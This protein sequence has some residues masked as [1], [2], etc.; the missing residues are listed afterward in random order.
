MKVICEICLSFTHY[1]KVKKKKVR[2]ELLL[3]LVCNLYF[4]LYKF[5]QIK[6]PK[7]GSLCSII[8]INKLNKALVGLKTKG[9]PFYIF[10]VVS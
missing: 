3:Y 6:Y 2:A 4:S 7:G 8:D 9:D 10:S 1:V 5:L